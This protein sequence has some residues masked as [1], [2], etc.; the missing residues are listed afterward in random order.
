MEGKD[1]ILINS[2]IGTRDYY[3]KG[4]LE[5]KTFRDIAE[6]LHI[7]YQDQI[8]EYA[9]SQLS[10]ILQNDRTRLPLRFYYV[11][12]AGNE[13]EIDHS[14]KV[15]DIMRLGSEVFWSIQVVGGS[16]NFRKYFGQH[17]LEL[18]KKPKYRNW[19]VIIEGKPGYGIY[20]VGPDKTSIIRRWEIK[21]SRDYPQTPPIVTSSP[22][23]SND[24]CW[25]TNGTLHYARFQ[26]G[27]SPWNDRVNKSTNPLY[28]LVI[29]LLQKYRLGV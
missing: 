17:S 21:P 23:Y 14:D 24:P 26:F 19:K 6:D 5:S 8:F 15:F 12:Q 4:N 7:K 25:D 9:K 22:P 20:S 18:V 28:S 11:D 10:N 2:E 16:V 1:L 13:N 27:G 29:E 3:G